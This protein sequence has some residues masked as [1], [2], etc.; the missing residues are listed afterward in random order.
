MANYKKSPALA[1]PGGAEARKTVTS[2]IAS[3]YNGQWRQVN[4][5]NPCPACGNP[6]WCAWTPDGALLKCE[7]SSNAPAGLRLVKP[8]DGGA[9]FA[10]G[11]KPTGNRSTAMPSKSNVS[12]DYWQKLADRFASAMTTEQRGELARNLGVTADSLAAVGV[13]VVSG[14]ELDSLHARWEGDSPKLAYVFPERDGNGRIV[15]LSLRCPAGRKSTPKGSRRG[16]IVPNGQHGGPVLIVEGA[17]DVAAAK[18]MGLAA[19]G[20]P[21]NSG[22]S[23][24][25][26]KMLDSVDC[27]VIGENDQKD[28]GAWPGRT[29]AKNIAKRLSATWGE[30]VNWALPPVGTKDIRS[31][32]QSRVAAGLDLADGEACKAAGVE[33]LAAIQGTAKPIKPEKISQAEAL[34]QLANELYRVGRTVDDEAFAVPI[35]GPN[36]AMMFRGS[37]DALRATLAREYRARTGKTPGAGALADAMMALQG[38]ALAAEAEPVHLRVANHDG[39]IVI[40]LGDKNGRAVIV[41][42]GGGWEVADVSPVLFRRTAL[43]SAMPEPEHGGDL[44]DLRSLINVDNDGWPLLLGWII[45]AFM[46]DIPRP[47][48]M[49]GGQHGA[50]KSVLSRY[51]VGITDPSPAPLRSQPRDVEQWAMAAAG[52]WVVCIDNVSAIP[53]WWSDAICKAVTGDGWIR[54]RLYT[55]SELAVLSFRRAVILTSIDAGALRGDLGDRLL[56]LDMRPFPD[57]RWVAETEL[58]RRYGRSKP[59]ILGAVLD[60]LACALLRLPSIPL[61]QSARMADF[62]RVLA[63]VDAELGTSAHAAYLNQRGRVAQ[64]VIEGDPVAV[65]IVALIER[66]GAFEGNAAAIQEEIKPE[67]AGKEWPANARGLSGRLRRLIPALKIVGIEAIPPNQSDKARKWRLHRAQ[68]GESAGATALT[69][70]PPESGDSDQE[71]ADSGGAVGGAVETPDRLPDRPTKSGHEAIKNGDSG[72]L[73]GLGGSTATLSDAELLARALADAEGVR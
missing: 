37:R 53:A 23:D 17:S 24:E 26:G 68:V 52:S 44:S 34:T 63:A 62:S 73:G 18:S 46:P 35:A 6:D 42:P 32:L 51:V 5:S 10:R 57:G 56:L 7:R 25:L 9:I 29:G 16:L 21:S 15:G 3:H 19:V 33:L 2:P 72:G 22:G 50:G 11:V 66:A 54:R 65:A 14:G 30:P 4:A 20:R 58:D 1:T 49:L 60:L 43:T 70:Q 45:A 67:R 8:Q 41:R 28:G 55:D 27:I 13:G 69:A 39:A 38:D 48:L 31:F 64:D 59:G 40:D 71:N 47:V 12:L 61:A 36:V